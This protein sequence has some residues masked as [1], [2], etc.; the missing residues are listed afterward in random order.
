MRVNLNNFPLFAVFCFIVCLGLNSY[1]SSV[2]FNNT[3]VDRHQFRQTQTAISCYYLHK[4][5]LKLSYQT[6]V[7]GKPW[8]IP[9]EFPTYQF[10]VVF[11]KKITGIKLDL[12]GRI[13]SLL[14]FYLSL[15][16]LFSLLKEMKFSLSER[17]FFSSFILLSPT[18]IFWSR[19]FM[20][21]S[22]SFFL[23][24]TFLVLMLKSI[25]NE[26]LLLLFLTCLIGS[27]AALT[28]IT[29]FFIFCIPAAIYFLIHVKQIFQWSIFRLLKIIFQWVIIFLIP[30][31]LFKIWIYYTD[32][33]K[34]HNTLAQFLISS[35]THQWVFGTIKQR[36][37]IDVWFQIMRHSKY[38]IGS[39]IVLFIGITAMIKN[40]KFFIFPLISFLIYLTSLLI[41]TNL[42]YVHDYYFY[43][44][45]IFLVFTCAYPIIKLAQSHKCHFFSRVILL[46]S[47][48][49][50]IHGY[51]QLYY[52]YQ[53]NNNKF[54]SPLTKAIK[55]RTSPSDSIIILGFDWDPVIPYYSKR[56]ALMIRPH[57][58]Y[59]LDSPEAQKAF[60][61]IASKHNI[62]ITSNHF[63]NTH[64]VVI[65]ILDLLDLSSTPSYTDDAG[66][67]Y[68]T[69]NQD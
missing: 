1:F 25:K 16:S 41:F 36:F 8:E 43:A 50:M 44:N 58:M 13:I 33:I 56:K 7:L 67:I 2:G 26:S 3:L 68:S 19:T 63:K 65:Q 27:L 62:F 35:N 59:Q 54:F 37:S 38:T 12:C 51:I 30:I 15:F 21:E 11:L 34:Q 18:Y 42:Y 39:F 47:L 22:L 6:P 49:L 17:L 57:K 23:S 61:S 14:F 28:K 24:I 46:S 31:I 10:L 45:S 53:A 66:I 5:G 60:Q 32:Q 55:R 48:A 9:L 4:E 29:T 69:K 52:P 40:Q 20:I 64:P